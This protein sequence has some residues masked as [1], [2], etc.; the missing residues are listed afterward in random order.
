MKKIKRLR[1]DQLEIDAP[2]HR[3]NI[4]PIY[5]Y[6]YIYIYNFNDEFKV[7]KLLYI[8]LK[9]DFFSS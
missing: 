5:I 4:Q 9:I 6:I 7:K 1:V 8:E 2:G 3:M